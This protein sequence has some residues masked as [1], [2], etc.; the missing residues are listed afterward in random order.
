MNEK[1]IIVGDVIDCM[2][3]FGNIQTEKLHTDIKSTISMETQTIT[4]QAISRSL[5]K[6]NT[7]ENIEKLNAERIRNGLKN[8]TRKVSRW[9]RDGTNQ[10]NDTTDINNTISKH[11][12]S[13]QQKKKNV[14]F[15]EK[16]I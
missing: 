8:F 10:K 4:N 1:D 11:D 16:N 15:A 7:K 3:L 13:E 9:L 6:Q 14:L 5:K 12:E 2:S